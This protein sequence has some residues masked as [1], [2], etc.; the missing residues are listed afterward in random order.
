[1]SEP[2]TPASPRRRRKWVW[3]AAALGFLLAAAG[4]LVW[5]AQR[6]DPLTAEEQPFVGCWK[7][8]TPYDHL[9]VND[10]TRTEAV[11]YRADRTV[12]AHCI[13]TR[14]GERSVFELPVK[15]H[16]CRGHL[17]VVYPPDPFS[18]A[19]RGDFR[20]RDETDDRITWQGPDRYLSDRENLPPGCT[21]TTVV[22]TRCPAPGGP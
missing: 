6:D 5:W 14:T 16:V 19:A 15:W 11:E 22:Y 2:A 1:M 4:G 18:R 10:P 7:P 9:W 20:L 12:R 3:C 8:S 13:E 21:G 17:I